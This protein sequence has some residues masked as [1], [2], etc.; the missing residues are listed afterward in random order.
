MEVLR[1]QLCGVDNNRELY[2]K[3]LLK[4]YFRNNIIPDD[5]RDETI[6][7]FFDRIFEAALARPAAPHGT[8]AG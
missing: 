2:L 6:M 1:A 3:L 8:P 4:P 5:A 7:R